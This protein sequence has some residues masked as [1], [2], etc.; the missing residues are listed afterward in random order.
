MPRGDMY[1]HIFLSSLCIYL[2]FICIKFTIQYADTFES[3][4]LSES[5]YTNCPSGTHRKP[6]RITS[7]P[8]TASPPRT[9][10]GAHMRT[11]DYSFLDHAMLPAS[12]MRFER[13]ILELKALDTQRKH[14]Q[15][16]IFSGLE[17]VAKVQSV[18]NSNEIEGIITSDERLLEIVAQNSAPLNHDEMEIAGYRDALDAIY[19][20]PDQFDVRAAD[21]LRL[22][23]TMLRYTPEG[24][25]H[26]KTTDNVIVE[27]D[28]AGKRS[29]RFEPTSVKD[30]PEAMEQLELAYRV[31]WSNPATDRL[32]LIPCVILDFLC[33][34]PFSDGNGRMSRL[35]TLLLMMKTGFDIGKYISFEEQ[36]NR[37]KAL[38]YE[39]LRQSSAG[40]HT[41]ENSYIPF[42]EN[43]LQTLLMCYKELDK[44]F[45]VMH[46]KKV[47]KANRIEAT[48]LNSLL[49]I[50]KKEIAFILPDISPT[51][52]EAVLGVMVREGRIKKIGAARSTRYIGA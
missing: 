4:Y 7:P 13:S 47:T 51:T 24:G 35:L 30:T 31:A 29:I 39:A 34:H 17:Q 33:I 42:I 21:L 40:W 52:I 41:N 16:G 45:A 5:S 15:P 36:I 26:Y 22:H 11:F 18:K 3:R 2:R 1:L 6:T 19:Q 48:V 25:G 23:E 14:T 10:K 9:P 12:L 27:I 38:Y 28:S 32:L 46:D 49:P 20:N 43:F 8:H 44:R 50:S 37:M